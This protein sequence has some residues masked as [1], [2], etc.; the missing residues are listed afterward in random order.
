M[1]GREKVAD[2]LSSCETTRPN[3]VLMMTDQ[4]RAD[5]CAREGYPLDTTP[6]LDRLAQQGTWFDHAYTVAPA[7]VPARVSL[8]T[9]RYPSATRVRSNHNTQDATYSA[10]LIDVLRE[11]GYATAMVG[12]N[13]SHLAPERVDHWFHMGH[14]GGRG[15]DPAREGPRTQQE[16]AFDEWLHALNHRASMEP[17]PFPLECQGPYRCVSDAARWIDALAENEPGTPFFLWLSFAE[18]HNPYQV[19]EPYYSMY[20]P[21]SLPP[22]L[23]GQ[24]AL[25]G[26]GFKY[27]FTWD[28]GHWGF[29]DYD[30]QRPRARANYVGMLRLIDDQVQRFVEH[31]DARGLRE[32]TIVV[33]LSDHGDFCGEYGLMRKGPEMPECL[34]RVPMSWTGP[35]IASAADGSGGGPHPAHVSLADVMPTLCEA[36]GVSLPAGVQGR[37]LWPLLCGEPYP[38]AEFESVY[39]E[40]GFGGLHYV[41][42]VEIVDPEQDGLGH[43]VGFDCL[44]SRSQSGTMRML[45][46]GRYKLVMDMQG[47]GQLYD[48]E[49]DPVE[50]ENLYGRGAP[51]SE[52]AQ[53]ERDLLADLLAWTI[54]VQDPLPLPRR[55]Y[56]MKTDPRNYWSPYR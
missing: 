50:L 30:E 5:L 1:R 19:P 2:R 24:S 31:L 34:M 35:G 17:A 32:N 56:V 4:Q 12:K 29:P 14:S 26:K 3:I 36:I 51:G 27:Q 6:N 37:S 44:N 28:L 52:L 54:R 41:D 45:R 20:P 11:Q 7:C 46:K 53:I 15:Q 21:E 33:F 47:R 48:L 10:D 13:H 9:G 23:S 43:G 49:A 22:T 18:P 38:T 25:E 16:A 42:A 39:G 55:R 8:L 40:Q